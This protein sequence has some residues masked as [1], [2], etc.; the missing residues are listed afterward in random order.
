MSYK[1]NCHTFVRLRYALKRAGAFAHTRIGI[2]VSDSL[3][4]AALRGGW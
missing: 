4:V 3:D 1:A 2:G